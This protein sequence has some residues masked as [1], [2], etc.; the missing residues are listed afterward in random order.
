[1]P[2][3]GESRDMRP[4]RDPMVVGLEPQ[5]EPVVED[6]EIAVPVAGHGLRHHGLN[7]LRYYADI[8]LFTAIIAEAIKADAI[9]EAAEQDHVVLKP[10]I[11]PPSAAA[12]TSATASAAAG[13]HSA[14]TTAAAAGTHRA[15]T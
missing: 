3:A 7:F 4:G 8:G 11:G 12:A 1:M 6:F 14:A 9:V 5:A 13:A 2:H 10:N 15:A